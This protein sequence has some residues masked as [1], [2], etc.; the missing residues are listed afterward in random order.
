MLSNAGPSGGKLG[1]V[2]LWDARAR[3]NPLWPTGTGTAPDA[4]LRRAH[5]APIT[6]I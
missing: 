4:A 6:V 3:R 1:P 5:N 2:F